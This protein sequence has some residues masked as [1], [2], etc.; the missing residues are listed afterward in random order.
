MDNFSFT[1][2]NSNNYFNFIN[3]IDSSIKT[4]I[5][6]IISSDFEEFD[7]QLKNSFE[8]KS[9]YYINKSNVSRFITPSLLRSILNGLYS[10][11]NYL[12][13]MSFY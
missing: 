10:K 4:Y 11:V 8:H 3:L 2:G 1:P 13:N 6:S 12:T 5:L 9:R 7:L